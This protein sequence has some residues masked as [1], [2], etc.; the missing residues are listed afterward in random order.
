MLPSPLTLRSTGHAYRSFAFGLCG[1]NRLPLFWAAYGRAR[2]LNVR[3]S[4]SR[5]YEEI[6]E[7]DLRLLAN[8]AQKDR[9]DVDA[10]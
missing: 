3:G 9:E 2:Y 10:D 7:E 1:G 5:S 8:L 6:T 4:M